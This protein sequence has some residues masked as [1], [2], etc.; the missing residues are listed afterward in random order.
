AGQLQLNVMEPVIAFTLLESIQL[1]RNGCTALEN[2]CIKGIK[3]SP[4][5]L[6]NSV[7]DSIGIVTAI[8]P[9]IGYEKATEIATL[10]LETGKGVY[11]LI[12]EKQYL[13]KEELDSILK[14][15]NMIIPRKFR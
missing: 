1:L 2:K 8:N 13:S 7:L 11:D 14:P 15:E 5:K 3:A 10:A 9:Y 6:R 4:E 12:L